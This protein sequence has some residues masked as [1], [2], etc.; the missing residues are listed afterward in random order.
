MILFGL[1]TSLALGSTLATAGWY[2]H[3][4]SSGPLVKAVCSLCFNVCGCRLT[5]HDQAAYLW[6]LSSLLATWRVAAFI[7]EENHGK[8]FLPI[9]R[10]RR[11]AAAEYVS[12]GYGEPGVKRGMPKPA[13]GN[14]TGENNGV[15]A[16]TSTGVG[17]KSA[18]Y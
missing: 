7:W 1:L 12:P 5:S 3:G 16:G 14:V 4:S 9:F 6:M 8:T 10:A 11:Q 15:G 18:R 2:V 13:D 17:G